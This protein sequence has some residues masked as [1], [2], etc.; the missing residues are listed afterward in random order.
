M[1]WLINRCLGKPGEGK[2]WK[3]RCHSGPAFQ[4][5]GLISTTGSKVNVTGDERPQL[6]AVTACVNTL[7]FTLLYILTIKPQKYVFV[8]LTLPAWMKVM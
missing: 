8:A 4:G 6:R 3:V 2:L 5:N 7:Y 1:G